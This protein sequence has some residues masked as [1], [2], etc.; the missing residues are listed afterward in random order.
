LLKNEGPLGFY[1]GTTAPLVGIGACVSIQFGA[2]EA[3]KRYFKG[4]TVNG[5]L[6]ISQLFAA[7]AFAG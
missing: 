1:K 7:G 2:L 3:A 6:G 4:Q 5:E